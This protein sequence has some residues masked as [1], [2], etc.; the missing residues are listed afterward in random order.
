M[1]KDALC[2]KGCFLKGRKVVGQDFFLFHLTHRHAYIYGTEDLPFN[3]THWNCHRTEVFFQVLVSYFQYFRGQ[4]KAVAGS[5]IYKI[6]S[7]LM[8]D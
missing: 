1:C 3:V 2:F 6:I 5:W 8:E 4:L 7:M